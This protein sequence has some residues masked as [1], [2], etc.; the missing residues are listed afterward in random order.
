MEIPH[1][2]IKSKSNDKYDWK[3]IDLLG[4]G[5]MGTV[6]KARD[7]KSHNDFALKILNFQKFNDKSFKKA[8]HEIFVLNVL[9]KEGGENNNIL[10]LCDF[11]LDKED[12]AQELGKMIDTSRDNIIAASNENRMIIIMKIASVSLQEIFDFRRENNIF[13]NVEDLLYILKTMVGG[14]GFA[15]NLG[16]AH[17]DIKPDNI[18]FSLETDSLLIADWSEAKLIKKSNRGSAIHNVRLKI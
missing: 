8:R 1:I 5:A 9:Q 18:L 15:M 6:Y 2:S 13:W 10:T 7:Q 16:I 4:K 11:F 17:R 14:L 12:S 3:I